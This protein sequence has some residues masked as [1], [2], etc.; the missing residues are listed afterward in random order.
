MIGVRALLKRLSVVLVLG[1]AAS[2]AHADVGGIATA[3]LN[4]LTGLVGPAI[5]LGVIWL[6][7][8]IM[9]RRA[10]FLTFFTFLV[11]VAILLSGG[12]F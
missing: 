3:V 9:T 5:T 4:E 12:F 11:G 7:I 2:P 10:A 8:L 1:L 6:G